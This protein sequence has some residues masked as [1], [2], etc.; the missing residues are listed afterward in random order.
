MIL[1]KGWEPPLLAFL[2]FISLIREELGHDVVLV[3]VPLDTTRTEVR[4]EDRE[5]W[6]NALARLDDAN[7][8]VASAV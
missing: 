6:S 1:T 7:L 2:D 4:P 5:V 8:L 3:V